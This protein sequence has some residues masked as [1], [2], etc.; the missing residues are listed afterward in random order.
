MRG[1]RRRARRVAL[2]LGGMLLAGAV[3]LAGLWA[4][5]AVRAGA[6]DPDPERRLARDASPDVP[7]VD[8][9]WWLAAN[10]GVVAWLSVPGTAVSLPVVRAPA[11]DPGFYLSHDV[12]GTWNPHGAVYLDASCDGIDGAPCVVLFGHHSWD[13]TMLAPL[14]GYADEDW[15]RSH[16]EV[17]VQTP[18]GRTRR[19]LVRAVDVVRADE[20][21]KRT[22]FADEADLEA[23]WRERFEAADVRLEE[24]PAETDQ[25]WCLVTCSY[26]RW[27][28][29]ERTMV[30]AC[31][32]AS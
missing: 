16:R 23:Y 22:E 31:E 10:P 24:A 3:A 13:G 32:D 14:A 20:P 6:C 28:G 27:P 11:G 2:A 9:E 29:S 18:D 17:V 15:A 30:L 4:A 25:L 1:S 5:S 21:V 12:F 19:L 26:T 8:W 7:A